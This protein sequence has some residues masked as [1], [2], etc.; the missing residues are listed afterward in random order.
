[1]KRK[2]WLVIYI[3]IAFFIVSASAFADTGKELSLRVSY[4][5]PEDADAGF[6][7]G[8]SFGAA[9]NDFV[10]L[11]FGTDVYFKSYEQRTEVAS[12]TGETWKS[13]LYTTDVSYKSFAIPL[14]LEVKANIQIIGPLAIFGHAGAGYQIFVVKE[15]NVTTGVS[16]RTFFGGFAWVAGVGPSIKLGNDTW[17]FVEAYYTGSTVKRNRKDITVDLP[18]YQEIDLSGFG[19]RAG[20]NIMAF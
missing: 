7:I 2:L 17:L 14:L 20:I 16:D 4:Y 8:G 15:Q 12:E 11:A 19:V 18:V 5:G 13:T 9:F 10:S 6:A 3:C 1:M